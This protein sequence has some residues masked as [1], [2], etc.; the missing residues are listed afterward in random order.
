MRKLVV[1]FLS[2]LTALKAFAF[3]EL[4]NRT[5]VDV[6]GGK[7][8]PFWAQEYIGADLVK[9]QMREM[10]ITTRVPVAVY[11]IGFEKEF[12]NLTF[13]I[14]VDRAMNMTRPIRAHH[15]TSVANIINGKGMMGVSEN[16]DYVQ[17]KRVAPA[18]YY[19]M[20]LKEMVDSP[21]FKPWVI[22]N[23][24]G[25]TAPQNVLE[26]A[27]EVDKMG[28]IWVMASGNS[29]PDAVIEEEK[30]APVISVGSY[31]P[32]GLQTIYSQESDQLDI[33][34]PA[35]EYEASI[36]AYGKDVLFGATSGATPLVSGSI[37]NIKALI[38][39]LTRTQIEFIMKATATKS[40]HSL[41][42]KDNKTG[43]FNS[44]K[45]FQVVKRL[46][47]QCGEDSACLHRQVANATNYA[48]AEVEMSEE[49]QK[50]CVSKASLPQ[51]EMRKLRKNFLLNSQ[52]A[53]FSKLLSCA[54]RNEGYSINADYYENIALIYDNPPVLQKKIQRQ[55]L[56][57]VLKGYPNSA[58]LRDMQL[59]EPTFKVVLQKVLKSKKELEGMSA[60]ELLERYE[61]TPKIKLAN[62]KGAL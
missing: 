10:G 3:V 4:E 16:I 54:Y 27:R 28:I 34:A 62:P 61:A 56:Q 39:Q 24:M 15:G 58:A 43:L 14:T 59:L 13:D 9:E 5:P 60:Q 7:L 25:W 18:I 2:I 23:S 50:V 42:L 44:F 26:M 29:Y 22:S 46:K 20:A 53:K 36:D 30:N 57:A 48:F 6:E 38:P 21:Q 8:T 31:S 19:L 40:F 12:I 52:N 41:Y 37:A 55:A 1:L 35:D 17:L 47:Q 11:D 33:V 45:M 32:R 51:D 49:T